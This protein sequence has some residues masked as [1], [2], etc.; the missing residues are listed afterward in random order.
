MNPS[1]EHPEP[2]VVR[3]T[4]FAKIAKLGVAL[5]LML[6]IGF[7]TFRFSETD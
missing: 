1:D 6:A 3:A 4:P 2:D 5:A 7:Q